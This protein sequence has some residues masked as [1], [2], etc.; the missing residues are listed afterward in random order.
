MSAPRRQ[1][2]LTLNITSGNFVMEAGS[3]ID[4]NVAGSCP[5]T[6]RNITVS[7]TTGNVD[8]KTGATIR[9]N[10][11]SGGFHSDHHQQRGPREH[12]RHRRVRWHDLRAW[13]E[14]LP[15]GGPITVKAG[16]DL[17][18]SQR[19]GPHQQPG[20]GPGRG[21]GSPGR[22]RRDHQRDE[23][24]PRAGATRSRTTPPRAAPM[25]TSLSPRRNP[26]TRPGKPRT[27]PAASEIWSGTTLTIDSTPPHKGEVNADIGTTGGGTGPRLD[28]P[29]PPTAP[30]RS[31][32]GTA[33]IAI[34]NCCGT[35]TN[36]FARTRQWR[37]VPEQRR[38]RVDP[39]PV[40]ISPMSSP[41]ATPSRPT[42]RLTPTSPAA[43]AARFARRGG[44][45]RDV[46]RQH[47]RSR[48]FHPPDVRSRREDWSHHSRRA[49]VPRPGADPR[50]Q[51]RAELDD[52]EAARGRPTGSLVPIAQRGEINLQACTGVNVTGATFP[53][54]SNT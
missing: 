11:C 15:G 6:G 10:G 22:L 14:A 37:D 38:R 5:N 32:D 31:T 28:R 48:R 50:V 20:P 24:S 18:E 53:V 16:C 41:A 40:V 33:T 46:H 29:P 12:R 52:P 1:A 39:D 36:I 54:N 21:P 43:S 44:Q 17:T 42:G 23:S 49:P 4:G 9:S 35:V 34:V 3:L 25:L 51:R 2:A 13:P 47:L 45:R 7:L 26:V 30:S 8:V 19:H 27:R